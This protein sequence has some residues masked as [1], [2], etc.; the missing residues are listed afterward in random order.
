MTETT[1]SLSRRAFLT[2]L[3]EPWR[4]ATSK[5]AKGTKAALRLEASVIPPIGVLAL[6]RMG[7]GPRPGDL[8][9]F[10]A[11]GDDDVS[12]LFAYIEQQLDPDSIDDSDL[13]SR[14]TAEQ[15]PT[16]D[17][18]RQELWQEYRRADTSEEQRRPYEDTKRLKFLRALYSKRQLLEVMTD[19]WHDHF[20]V[21]AG[22]N[23]IR[24]M[25]MHYDRDVIRPHV[26]GNFREM[27]EAVATSTC[28]LFYLDNYVNSKNGPNE[29]W[30][31]ELLELHT[32]GQDAYFGSIPQ[33]EVPGFPDAPEGY[34]EADVFAVARCFT[35]WS[36]DYKT[37]E[38]DT[39]EF[40]YR[41]NKHENSEKLVLGQTLPADQDVAEPMKDGRDVLD[42]VAGH[43]ATAR[44][45]SYK[46][47]R[48]L[49]AD[50]PPDSLVT[51]AANVF[52]ANVSAPDQLAQ[53]IRHILQS[54]E[55]RSTWNEKFKRP[56]EVIASA[57][58]ALDAQL[59]FDYGADWTKT[60]FRHFNRIGQ[61]LFYWETPDGYP[62][63]G[64][65][66]RS[67]NS[68]VMRWR[69]LLWLVDDRKADTPA[70]LSV[71]VVA[72]TPAENQSANQL[73]DYWINRIF[74][75]E[76]P[77]AERQIIVDFMAQGA[78]PDAPLP[79]DV[80][81]SVQSRLRNMTA[82]ILGSELYQQ[83]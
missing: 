60:F 79:W 19:F 41:P 26:F 37:S 47:C 73:A 69:H 15:F 70:D 77:D 82:L 44:H 27:L 22:Q 11:L 63:V 38:G 35:G 24:S 17:K 42:I 12:R 51:S 53:V 64:E 67:S 49:I 20:N 36:V 43:E 21:D 1:T 58:R 29:N 2:A 6:N 16:K 23:V 72:Q 8:E 59:A 39:G 71:D 5:N 57:T 48:R 74:G 46:L 66:W 13:E 40:L 31:R 10:E 3:G 32:L 76:I 33:E 30:A 68:Y 45:I 34:V 7:F 61:P 65:Y 62:D 28:M 81:E 75:Y 83:R 54:P 55:F 25:I 18:T 50:E 80:D 52:A 4:Q 78:D 9:A 14:I 56:F